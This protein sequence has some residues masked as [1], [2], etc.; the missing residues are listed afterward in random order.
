ML[1]N[2]MK[3]VKFHEKKHKVDLSKDYLFLVLPF[4]ILHT[5]ITPYSNS[6]WKKFSSGLKLPSKLVSR[7]HH[8]KLYD[9]W[10]NELYLLGHK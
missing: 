5:F 1:T 4:V 7:N 3:D 8:L 2:Y 6:L 10:S 9:V